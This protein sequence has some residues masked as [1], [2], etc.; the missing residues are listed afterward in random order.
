MNKSRG[1]FEVSDISGLRSNW[2]FRPTKIFVC[3]YLPFSQYATPL[4]GSVLFPCCYQRRY[5]SARIVYHASSVTEFDR[6]SYFTI[7]VLL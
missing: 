6:A 5:S 2:A 4:F 1:C 3:R 7:N